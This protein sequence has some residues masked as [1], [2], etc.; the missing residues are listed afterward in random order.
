M[1]P[2]DNFDDEDYFLKKKEDKYFIKGEDEDLGSEDNRRARYSRYEENKKK[3][4][5]DGSESEE[6]FVNRKDQNPKRIPNDDSMDDDEYA[7]NKSEAKG[8]NSFYEKDE[9]GYDEKEEYSPSV[10][11]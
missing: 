10:N 5:L 8:R 4:N 2:E 3:Y 11:K 9:S 1:A 6:D 7:G